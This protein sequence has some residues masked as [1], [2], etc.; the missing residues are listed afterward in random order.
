MQKA[1][2]L[3]YLQQ[4]K[5]DHKMSSLY[6]TF[7]NDW[8]NF[9]E[10]LCKKSPNFVVVDITNETQVQNIVKYA[11]ANNLKVRASAG[12][13][14]T[15]DTINDPKNSQC[16]R[17]AK[18]CTN[19]AACLGVKRA[20]EERYN[21]SFS[22]TPFVNQGTN[23]VIR[24][25]PDFHSVKIHTDTSTATVTA[26]TQI[27]KLTDDLWKCGYSLATS[28]ENPYVTAVG[29]AATGGHGTGKDQPSFSGLIK[30]MRI[31][32]EDGTIVD[33][34]EY[35]PH[36]ETIRA[37]HVGIF[38][39]VL[40]IDIVI[41]DR[42]W[43]EENRRPEFSASSFR[44]GYLK[45]Y[46]LNHDYVTV[47][48]IPTYPK[49]LSDRTDNWE[50]RTWDKL[51]KSPKI[52][53]HPPQCVANFFQHIK[54][55]TRRDFMDVL[56]SSI[57]DPDVMRTFLK[58]SAMIEIKKTPRKYVH[59][60]RFIACPRI[61]LPKRTIALEILY[62][63]DWDNFDD[64]VRCHL[65]WLE[66]E[67]IKCSNKNQFPLTNSVS[68]KFFKGTN[69][70]LSTSQTK[71]NEI[72]VAIELVTSYP[73]PHWPEFRDRVIQHFTNTEPRTKYDIGTYLPNDSLVDMY[74]P[75]QWESW[76]NAVIDWYK[77]EENFK[78]SIFVTEY[79]TKLITPSELSESSDNHD[80]VEIETQIV[81]ETPA[82]NSQINVQSKLPSKMFVNKV[83]REAAKFAA[84][85]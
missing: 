30:K 84:N 29:L 45:N 48:S 81:P 65:E 7:E 64:L 56:N 16:I 14:D 3:Q 26:G 37:S 39:I 20:V 46:V 73:N 24:F 85:S 1:Q 6:D 31:C 74:T 68:L 59:E 66:T 78:K 36:F 57:D 9:S 19:I 63:I 52:Y 69:G 83:K 43:L 11:K 33:I 70:G 38:G 75:D 34:N 32:K 67:L 49:S 72:T 44:D 51:L 62:P 50:I 53:V 12:W 40:S 42:F 55:Q 47:V 21:E 15:H 28:N 13:S 82:H 71:E 61:S 22:L 54:T 2:H 79:I 60:D 27:K 4:K 35:H 41:V 76:M 23:I 25:A 80:E 77:S 10:T 18:K 58:I 8:K 5:N 17:S